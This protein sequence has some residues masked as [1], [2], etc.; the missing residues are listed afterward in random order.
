MRDFRIS[1]LQELTDREPGVKFEK[2]PKSLSFYVFI[3]LTLLLFFAIP[4]SHATLE[5]FFLFVWFLFV[6]KNNF[7]KG[8]TALVLNFEW[9]LFFQNLMRK[10]THFELRWFHFKE[11]KTSSGKS[12]SCKISSV[13]FSQSVVFLWHEAGLLN[14]APIQNASIFYFQIWKVDF[15]KWKNRR[16]EWRN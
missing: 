16:R 15:S 13:S 14:L 11:Q 6:E 1:W 10:Q 7:S 4:N 12:V 8:A 9:F 2:V 3:Y 5:R